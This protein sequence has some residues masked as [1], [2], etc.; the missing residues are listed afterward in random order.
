[1]KKVNPQFKRKDPLTPILGSKAKAN[2]FEAISNNKRTYDLCS[3]NENSSFIKNTLNNFKNNRISPNKQ[4][5]I[6]SDI[7]TDNKRTSYSNNNITMSSDNLFAYMNKDTNRAATQKTLGLPKKKKVKFLNNEKFVQVILVE[8]YK[9]FQ[10]LD[11]IYSDHQAD[12]DKIKVL[13]SESSRNN[14]NSKSNSIETSKN[15]IKNVSTIKAKKELLKAKENKKETNIN[16]G[17][18]NKS[19]NSKAYYDDKVCKCI[20]F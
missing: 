11:D 14:S 1:M 9:K 12:I 2:E 5:S 16:R 18:N 15:N 3:G 20:I 10:K 17:N 7:T 4:I 19:K 13:K 6:L 8:S